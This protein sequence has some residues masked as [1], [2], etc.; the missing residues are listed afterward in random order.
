MVQLCNNL[1]ERAV[2]ACFIEREAK[3]KYTQNAAQQQQ[4]P[5]MKLWKAQ[6]FPAL[7]TE[8]TGSPVLKMV[9]QKY[10]SQ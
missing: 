10:I 8:Y 4:I 1:N 7:E 5:S 6:V 2:R 3:G 9:G